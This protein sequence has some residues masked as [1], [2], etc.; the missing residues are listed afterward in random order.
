[1]DLKESWDGLVEALKRPFYSEREAFQDRHKHY[2]TLAKDSELE[3]PYITYDPFGLYTTMHLG[4]ANSQIITYGD[5]VKRWR[6]AAQL[7]EVDDALSEIVSEAIVFDEIEQV[8]ELNL[9]DIELT[10]NIKAKI[11]ESF[12][13]ILYLLDFNERGDELF[14]QWYVDATLNFEV[15]YNN[16]KIQDGIQKLILL[17]PYDLQKF[18]NEQD[19]QIR[20]YINKHQ[21]Y[22]PIKDLENA[23]ITYFDEQITQISSGILSPDKKNY[24]SPLQK[25]MKAINQLYTIEDSMILMRIS[26]ST[27]K[28]AFY[29]DTGNLPKTKAEEYLKQMIN[30]YRQKKVYNTETGTV[31]NGQKSIS[32]LEDFW[33]GVNKEGRGTKVENLPGISNNFTSFEDVEYFLD[34]VYN[35]LNIPNTRLNKES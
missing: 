6:D 35:A 17:P 33:F 12:S 19:S 18:K 24:F 20:W 1:M 9:D 22:N 8:I 7:P 27:E 14:R 15:V 11:Q 5:M 2:T 30:K 25:A 23:E 32:L 34:K 3:N 13:R 31:D 16:R 21:T 29:I 26:K 4:G 28:R 10:E